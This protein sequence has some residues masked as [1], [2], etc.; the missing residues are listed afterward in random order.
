MS[1]PST[2]AT[3]RAGWYVDP[4]ND[5]RMRYWDG[6][7][8][9]RDVRPLDGARPLAPTSEDRY[10]APEAD[11]PSRET[12]RNTAAVVLGVCVLLFAAAGF[13]EVIAG[14]SSSTSNPNRF[15]ADTA[16]SSPSTVAAAPVAPTC[17]SSGRHDAVQAVSWLASDGI[18]V[19][20]RA[21]PPAPTAP[22][23]HTDLAP[24]TSSC[25]HTTFADARVPAED[26]LWEFTG[27]LEAVRA[28]KSA[29]RLDSVTFVAGYYLVRLDARLAPFQASYANA[30]RTLVSSQQRLT[31]SGT[32]TT[33]QQVPQPRGS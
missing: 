14:N 16:T 6:R 11:R 18:P 24:L 26:E 15:A 25:S 3:Q 19:S 4:A 10:A 8:W 22:S 9:S 1:E 30:L 7:H 28:Q 12:N 20:D 2:A 21:A 23:E 29:S 13:Y 5:A 33:E 17:P 32:T 31:P 27:R